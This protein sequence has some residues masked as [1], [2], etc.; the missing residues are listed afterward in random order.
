MLSS[1]PK[2]P[3][4]TLLALV[5]VLGMLGLAAAA[6]RTAAGAPGGATRLSTQPRH[7][8]QT[9]L[10][11]ERIA[12]RALADRRETRTRSGPTLWGLLLGVAAVLA[13]LGSAGA[14]RRPRT[15]VAPP[16]RPGCVG[17]RAPPALRPA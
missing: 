10:P 14:A 17:S 16:R 9:V 6:G 7:G 13:A 1:P 11:A 12:V 2:R 4:S 3:A 8:E 15:R 5:V